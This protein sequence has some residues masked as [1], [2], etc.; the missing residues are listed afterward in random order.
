MILE[1]L[2]NIS[3]RTA[4][5][6]LE[7]SFHLHRALID[8]VDADRPISDY[9]RYHSGSG[10]NGYLQALVET[11][12]ASCVSM[13]GYS[14]IR[15]LVAREATRAQVLA[16]NHHPENERR[17]QQLECFA[18][19]WFPENL[20]YSW[21]ELT[22]AVTSSLA[23]HMLLAYAV[24]PS[25]SFLDIADACRVYMPGLSLLATMLDSYVDMGEDLVNGHHSY[26]SHYTD[27]ASAIRRLCHL[28]DTALEQA[29][30]LR[31]GDRHVVIAAAMIAMYLSSNNARSLYWTTRLTS[32]GGPLTMMLV[33]IL[34]LWRLVYKLEGE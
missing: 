16:I 20:G 18:R 14:L 28:I 26:I 13:A 30:T 29:A 15:E 3:E 34:R 25:A 5:A 22:G 27:E 12:R 8:A 4:D 21:F 23:V 2:D 10:D 31:D 24:D 32:A 11:C 6:G 19:L 1:F 17:D 9:Y 7:N 33:P